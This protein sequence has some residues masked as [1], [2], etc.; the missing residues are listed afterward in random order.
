M[1][2]DFVERNERRSKLKFKTL[3]QQLLMTANKKDYEKCRA[4]END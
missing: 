3:T 2:D 4:K 1:Y